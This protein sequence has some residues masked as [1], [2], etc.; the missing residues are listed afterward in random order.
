M[1][2]NSGSQHGIILDLEWA[3]HLITNAGTRERRGGFD[4]GDPEENAI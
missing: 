3:L 4:N 2:L 1:Q